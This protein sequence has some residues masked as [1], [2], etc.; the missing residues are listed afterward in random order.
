MT[1]SVKEKLL[2]IRWHLAANY[3]PPIPEGIQDTIYLMFEGYFE[4][5]YLKRDVAR[6]IRKLGLK[7]E[8]FDGCFKR[9]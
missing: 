6:C 3:Y 9:S 1:M 7:P 2:T 5:R 4:N 8:Q